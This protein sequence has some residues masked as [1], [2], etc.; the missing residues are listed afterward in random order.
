MVSDSSD[1][2]TVES[3]MSVKTMVTVPS[4]ARTPERSGCSSWTSVRAHRGSVVNARRETPHFGFG[5]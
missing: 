3:T 5:Q 4:A 1:Y 2:K